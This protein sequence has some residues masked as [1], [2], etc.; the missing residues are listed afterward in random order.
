MV[1]VASRQ[2]E[3]TLRERFLTLFKGSPLPDSEILA[4]L[5]L[6]VSR[7]NLARIFFMHH[8]YRQILGVHGV[9]MEF[10][11]RWGQNLALFCNFRG[12]YE[13]FNYTRKI[14][15]FDTFEGF[16]EVDEKDGSK[17]HIRPGAYNVT[18]DYER[19]LDKILSYHEQESPIPHLRKYDIVKGDAEEQCDL[20]LQQHTET[21][22]ALAYFDL[23]LY[24]PT[25]RCLEL[26]KD[27]L[28]KGSVLGFDEL[29]SPD[30]PG[31]TVA[32]REVLGLTDLRINRV[33]W[34]PG[35][36]YIIVG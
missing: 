35:T 5:G 7:Q 14:V 12:M 33:P 21:I 30:F 22:V 25:R 15:G 34:N 31:E 3:L 17:K 36:S 23:D 16:P 8:L 1:A 11:V 10:G 6:Y 29:C 32:L 26:V 24:R 27:R 20:Y 19:Y 13:P 9:V 4:N 18:E 2:E 28:V